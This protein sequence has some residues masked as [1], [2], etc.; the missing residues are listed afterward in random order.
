MKLFHNDRFKHEFS[1][2]NSYNCNISYKNYSRKY[3]FHVPK[4][5]ML[6]SFPGAGGGGGG[7]WVNFCWVCATSLSEPL[8]HYSLG[9]QM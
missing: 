5:K 2:L 9:M 8:P 7:A 4:R 3:T 6:I 1:S